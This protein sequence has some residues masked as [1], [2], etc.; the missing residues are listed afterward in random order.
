M[1]VLFVVTRNE[2]DLLRL[3]L[4]H[5][6]GW[7]FD[8]VAIADNESTDA[9]EEVLREYGDAVTVLRIENPNERFAALSALLDRIER[10]RGDIDWVAVSD[11]DEF[12]W[13]P[14]TDLSSLL[15]GVPATTVAVNSVQ[16][17]FLPTELDADS[18][19]VY[20][21]RTYRASDANSPLHTSYKAGKTFYR[22]QWL[23]SHAIDH[24]HWSPNVPHPVMRFGRPLVHHYMIDG[25]DNFVEKVKSLERWRAGRPHLRLGDFKT[26]WW[27]LLEHEGEGGLRA[28]YR[29]EYVISASRIPVHLARGE[30][31]KDAQFAAHRCPGFEGSPSGN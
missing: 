26:K 25:E 3:N 13:A 28:F 21:R 20:C 18:G 30:L 2:A 22:G 9:T 4:S 15:A 6:L 1:N 14:G 23:K 31:V 10:Q 12:W 16:K 8:H 19:P 24:A 17:L 11:T 5:H 27:N 7:G 29:N